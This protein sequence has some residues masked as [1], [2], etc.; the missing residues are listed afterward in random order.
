[1]DQILESECCPPQNE[2]INIKKCLK[3][4]QRI[5]NSVARIVLQQPS[6]SSRDTLHWTSC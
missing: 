2:H 1:M 5:Q 6:L 4:L 3:R